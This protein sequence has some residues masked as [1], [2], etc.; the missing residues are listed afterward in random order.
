MSLKLG[1]SFNRSYSLRI[2]IM[3]GF[4]NIGI[5]FN[6]KSTFLLFKTD[7]DFKNSSFTHNIKVNTFKNLE[8]SIFCETFIDLHN[9]RKKHFRYCKSI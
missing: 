7:P 5:Y 1:K 3:D 6:K 4:Y 2:P 9:F 8:S